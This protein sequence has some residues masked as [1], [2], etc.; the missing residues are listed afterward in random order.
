MPNRLL[1]VGWDAADWKLLHPLIDAGKMPALR[2]VVEGGTSGSMLCSQPLIPAAQW[3]SLVTG[4]RAWQHR[5]CHQAELDA[6]IK[7]AVPASAAHRQSAALWEILARCGRKS[8]VVGWPVTHSSHGE[9]VTIVSN[10]FA[11]PTTGP[12]I[13][14]WPPAIAGTYWPDQ[15]GT[16]LDRLRVSPEDIQ[17]EVISHYVPDWKNLD[18][19]RDRRLGHLRVFLATDLS[20][21]AAMMELLKVGD[22]DF[23]AI[24]YPALG[25]ITAMFLPFLAPRRDW[26]SEQEFQLY[27]QTIPSAY[28][29]LDRLL[30]SL[31]EALGKET[32]II[33]TSA[34]G[35]NLHLPPRPLRPADNELWKSPYGVLAACGPRFGRDTLV[36][37]ATAQD[38][39]P[40]ILTWFG[41]PIGED[42]EGRVLV[43][44]FA[45]VPE[46][47]RVESW[48]LERK[49]GRGQSPSAPRPAGEDSAARSLSLESDWNLARSFLD[50]ARY[51]EALP[52]LEKVFFSFPERLDFGHALFHCQLTVKKTQEAAET[53]DVLLER[54]PPGIGGLL[55]RVELLIAKGDRKEARSLAGEILAL[56]PSEPEAL[57]R[58]GMIFWRLRE[59]NSLVQLSQ[60]ALQR[61]ENEALAWLGLAEGC[62]RLHQPDRAMEA[63]H[64]AIGLNYFLPQAH[65]V[66]ARTLLIQ[67]RWAEAH[68]AMQTV[69]RLQPGNRAL[70]TYS[71]RA[72][73]SEPPRQD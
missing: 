31:I 49:E 40:T 32:A 5:V 55:P 6:Q 30:R 1:L 27:Q 36:L 4:K 53:L 28:L 16:K 65:L 7:R 68:A 25:A 52:L 72:G 70:A 63:A 12:G 42:M 14:P 34:H 29:I 64:R 46:V 59:W 3:T 41:L 19:K 44:A 33:L 22:W 73:L 62:L 50:A 39:T 17:A 48:E 58:L 15:L 9:R 13:K 56:K 69:L 18:Q 38:L 47:T 61:N 67:G 26:V 2:G 37:G 54:I 57:R 8:L 11:E 23:A 45:T 21:H 51:D 20:H 10:R 24:N 43:E 35:V 71:R 66:L 60:E